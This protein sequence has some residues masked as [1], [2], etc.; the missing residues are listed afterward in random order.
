MCKKFRK[1]VVPDPTCPYDTSL[2]ITTISII[3][4]ARGPAHIIIHNDH[5][6]HL[7]EYYIIQSPHNLPPTSAPTKHCQWHHH[8]HF[9]DL[10]PLSISLASSYTAS[11]RRDHHL[12]HRRFFN[13]NTTC[14]HRELFHTRS[15]HKAT[16]ADLS[17]TAS[18]FNRSR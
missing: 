14:P 5:D 13:S 6:L 11:P 17:T 1:G 16:S 12:L 18:I 15:I 10:Q 7:D 4:A 2:L 3:S 9:K 8:D